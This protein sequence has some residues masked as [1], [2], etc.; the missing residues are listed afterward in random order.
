MTRISVILFGAWGILVPAVSGRGE[1]PSFDS[2]KSLSLVQTLADDAMEGRKSGLPGAERAG[3]FVAD[4]FQNWGLEPAGDKGTYFQRFPL[5]NLFVVRKASLEIT[6]RGL[7]RTFV[8]QRGLFDDWRVCDN[9]GSGKVRAEIVLAGF[10]LRNVK[11][12]YDDYAGVDVRGKVVLIN[13]GFPARLAVAG[14]DLSIE[15]RIRDARTLGAAAVLIAPNPAPIGRHTSFPGWGRV[16]P[17]DFDPGFIVGGINEAV[18]GFVTGGLPFDLRA[19][20]STIEAEGK[21]RP[22]ATGVEARLEVKASLLP[23]SDAANVL[24]RLP[25]SDPAI[26]DEVVILGAH[27][28][29]LGFAPH[30]EVCNGANDNASGVAVVMEAARA[31]RAS[32]WRPRRTIVFALWG[33]EE[34]NL[35]GSTYYAEH[36]LFPLEKT[37]VNINLDCVGQGT[38]IGWGGI[39]FST[40]LYDF[41]KA[42]LPADVMTKVTPRRPVGG[43]DHHAFL[44]K[45]VPA[46]HMVGLGGSVGIHSPRDDVDLIQPDLLNVTGRFL[47][48]ATT[49][50]ADTEQVLIADGR[51][52]LTKFRYEKNVNFRPM[53]LA[54]AT[55]KLVGAARPEVDGQLAI[56]TIPAD[57]TLAE[58]KVAIAKQLHAVPA[59]EDSPVTAGLADARFVRDDPDWLAPC[60]KLGLK[61]IMVKLAD[62]EMAGGALAEPSKRLL[63]AAERSKL[64]IV[65]DGP[66][67]EHAVLAMA[68]LKRP[69]VLL[70]G[71]MPALPTLAAL[72]ATSHVL[73]LRWTSGLTAEAYFQRLKAARTALGS[74]RLI[75]WNEKDLWS[76]GR[77]DYVKLARLMMGDG[78][79]KERSPM[80][81]QSALADVW[82]STWLRLVRGH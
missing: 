52:A 51:A 76:E 50:L 46:F 53:P 16:E 81:H 75:A 59:G 44:A 22:V 5:E 9:S 60:A 24:A 4:T 58:A 7:T 57:A 82:S 43:S 79:D 77:T 31:M 70:T 80:S 48:S 40:E 34:I 72:K 21:P 56:V 67:A 33:G 41:L 11:T 2:K 28:D 30:G 66:D 54:E 27:L 15:S 26:R 71:E 23:K 10:G 13:D 64:V 17:K 68:T 39:Y 73:G 61:F 38:T 42:R 29:G 49:L 74:E 37:L 36:P 12:G 45:G 18:L 19:Y 65:L 62:L 78:W 3:K 20:Y 63:E 69:A 47:I 8:H 35:V 25:G 55:S 6:A 32:G 1:A 14:T